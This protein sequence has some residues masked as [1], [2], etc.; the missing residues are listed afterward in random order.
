MAALLHNRFFACA[1]CS[2]LLPLCV[3]FPATTPVAS[4]TKW[5]T[6]KAIRR[7]VIMLH[8]RTFS[9]TFALLLNSTTQAQ[10]TTGNL[11]G[12]ILDSEARPLA[13]ADVIVAGPGLQGTRGTTTD[14]NGHFRVMALPPG[15]YA[16]KIIHIAHHSIAYS[17]VAISLGRTTTLGEVRLT[18]KT[19][20]MPEIE[21]VRTKPHVDPTTT[22][23]GGSLDSKTFEALPTERSY[24]SLITLLPQ[25]NASYFGD[26]TSIAGST[27]L[28]N[29]YFIDGVNVTDGI[30]AAASTNLPY[31]FVKEVEVRTGG[32]EPEFGRA[33]GGLVNVVTHSGGNEFH[34]Q[35]F[36]FFTNNDFAGTPSRGVVELGLQSFSSYDVGFSLGGPIIRDE[37][38]FFTAYNPTFKQEVIVIPGLGNYTDKKTA[39]LF[40]AKLNW[41]AAEHTNVTFS[42]FGDPVVHHRIANPLSGIFGSP[43][44]L[45]NA[46]PFLSLLEEGG[47]NLTLSIRHRL[48]PCLFI[49]S[50]LSRFDRI[51]NIRGETVRGRAE[52]TI[53]GL[54]NGVWS[55][56]YLE[57]QEYRNIRTIGK[58][59]GTFFLSDHTLKAGL[60]Y[61]DILSKT[62]RFFTN[63]G[64]VLRFSD[65]L[66]QVI[67]AVL[68]YRENANRAPSFFIQ[69]SWLISEQLRINLGLRWDGQYL[70]GS[71]GT[72]AQSISDEF[73]PRIG[74][75]FQP[76]EL[77]AQK[78][79]GS[80]GRFYQQL[81]TNLTQFVHSPWSNGI[82]EFH[83]DPRFNPA[84][85]DTIQPL[86][87]TR[88]QE[89]EGLKGEYFDE[90]T[91]G[92]ER[93]LSDELTLGVRGVYR[94]LGEYINTALP[95]DSFTVEIAY[96]NP[97][98]GPLSYLPKVQRDY[99]ALE[100]TLE[101]SRGERFNFLAS[102][103]LSRTY[104]N[105]AGP[106]NPFT[107]FIEPNNSHELELGEQVRNSWGLLPYDRTHSFKFI[108]SYRFDFGLTFGSTVTWQ[109]GTPLSELGFN[110]H[111]IP[112][113]YIFLQQ[114]GT[115]GRMP[116]VWDLSLRLTYDL[117]EWI[118]SFSR[119]KIILDVFHIGNP[120]NPVNFD[121]IHYFRVENGNQTSPNPN[122]LKPTQYQPPMTVRLGLEVSF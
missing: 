106:Y 93:R 87:W 54:D 108:S 100:I 3:F 48:T 6:T 13:R 51:E 65:S 14:E 33:A 118:P 59:S 78:I 5:S 44:R 35:V 79:F 43:S 23:L 73:Q 11:E 31:N 57:T 62:E 30:R 80:Y 115:A 29:M 112:A 4:Q 116:S 52:P 76:G 36:A 63:P 97:G 71:D 110:S 86:P 49:E 113:R 120:R 109:T 84:A 50:S 94:R 91:L 37:L 21:V 105:I 55:G 56:G 16:A 114:R 66:Y 60:E 85:G 122:Y 34:G 27:G 12:R 99:H 67:Y 121:Q 15:V 46:D 24:L 98:R 74:F 111:G 72:V 107:G 101:K 8:R 81:P 83:Q 90:F 39:H 28:E 58:I 64:T 102:Y 40:A 2:G 77:G 61:E 17:D 1:L 103:V 32:Y 47:V 38:W 53:V 7:V 22:T 42:T 92:Y 20:E 96:G 10:Q 75:T 41:Q 95:A 82:L 70:V 45:E 18:A 25:A 19:V 26:G 119:P 69:D 9:F 88:T 117:T 89:V 104:G 68:D